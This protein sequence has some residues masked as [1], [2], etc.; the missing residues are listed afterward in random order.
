MLADEDYIAQCQA[1]G[2][3]PLV[4]YPHNIHFLWS[5]TTMEG[6]SAVAIDSA[7]TSRR[8][9]PPISRADF[10]ALQDF[11]VTPYYAL[12]RFG[13][14]EEILHRGAAAANLRVCHGHVALRT[15]NRL[16]RAPAGSIAR[17]RS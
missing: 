11:M 6:R 7:R 8:R 9:F 15:R 1:Q 14:W 10:V 5:A 16:H 2:I 12:V 17:N 3:Y 4:Y 13:R